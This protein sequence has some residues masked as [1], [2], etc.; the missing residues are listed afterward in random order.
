MDFN[1]VVEGYVKAR[2]EKA[3]LKAAFEKKVEGLNEWME[4]AELVI[5][6]HLNEANLESIKTS[7]GT[8]YK[9]RETSATVA[10]WDSTLGYIR[11]N[12]AWHML[13][14]RVNKTAVA[15]YIKENKNVPPGVNW[16]ERVSIGIRR[17]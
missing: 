17:S 8:A 16:S 4:K 2:D 10:D 13:D 7:A 12:E 9:K 15:E 1:A 6:K 5:L 3:A 11:E 14:H